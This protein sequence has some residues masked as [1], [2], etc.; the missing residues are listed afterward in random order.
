MVQNFGNLPCLPEPVAESLEVTCSGGDAFVRS[1]S[2]STPHLYYCNGK[3]KGISRLSRYG[4]TCEPLTGTHGEAVLTSYLEAFPA[5][6][7]AAQE[8]AQDLRASDLD[9]GWKW[10]ESWVKYDRALCLW[11]TRQCSLVEGLDEY[12]ETWP[13]WGTMRDGECW[14]HITPVL[15]TSATGSGLWPTPCASD[16]KHHGKERYILGSRKKWADGIRNAP[17]TEKITY[18]YFDS[19]LKEE[20]Y[21]VAH[22]LMMTWPLGW[23]DLR[24][25]ETDKF[26]QWLEW[27]GGSSDHTKEAPMEPDWKFRGDGDLPDDRPEYCPH[28]DRLASRCV[29]D[30][31]EDDR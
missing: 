20:L 5:K 18:A 31:W 14:G 4:M 6:I 17:P 24:P 13:I 9:C 19:G 28:C 22:E 7:S 2:T 23:T 16:G 25:L 21:P 10:P 12:S 30:G 11:K 1:S 26:R 8:K 3:T 27:H 15:P 29:C